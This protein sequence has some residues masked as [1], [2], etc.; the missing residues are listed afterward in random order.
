MN[1]REPVHEFYTSV[2]VQHSFP[3]RGVSPG[4]PSPWAPAGSLRPCPTVHCPSF[5]FRSG[6]ADP[7]HSTRRHSIK[8]TIQSIRASEILDAR[9][10]PT[11]EVD[12][13]LMDGRVARAATPS[14]GSNGVHET[15]ERRDADT[16][17]YGGKGVRNA[18]S[19][20]NTA[21]AAAVGRSTLA[22]L[23][24]RAAVEVPDGPAATSGLSAPG[25]R[26]CAGSRR[27]GT[28]KPTGYQRLRRAR[29]SPR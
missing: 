27:C 2:V 14:G 7:G 9:G 6:T 15:V 5:F 28:G 29:C 13:T 26:T 21:L 11:V 25:Y 19:A 24:A 20:V 3:L 16:A 4:L 12:L 18:V 23:R 8:T 17:Q 10:N 22:C 1:H